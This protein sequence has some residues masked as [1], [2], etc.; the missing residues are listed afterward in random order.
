LSGDREQNDC[1]RPGCK[2]DT[3]LLLFLLPTA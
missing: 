3:R 2:H 1:V